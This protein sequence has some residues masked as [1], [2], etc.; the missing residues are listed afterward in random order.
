MRVAWD[1]KESFLITL[2]VLFLDQVTKNH[3]LRILTLGESIPIIKN[4]FHLSLVQN[5]GI[6]FGLFQGKGIFFIISAVLIIFILI[7]LLGLEPKNFKLSFPL[8]LIL[9]GAIGN[10]IDRLR[11]GFVVDFLDF[12]VWPVFNI[13]DS[14][15]TIGG[16][17]LFFIL[18][19]ES[20]PPAKA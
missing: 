1:K 17:V 18:L 14:A 16:I 20:K 5:T 13:A 6:A 11:F 12:R 7:F 2:A 9:G 8:A 3:I 15:I 4:I 10:L 19:R